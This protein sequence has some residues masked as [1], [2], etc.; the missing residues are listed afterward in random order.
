MRYPTITLMVLLGCSLAFAGRVEETDPSIA[1]GGNNVWQA[2][3]DSQASAGAYVVSGSVGATVTFNFTGTSVTLW[4]ELDPSGGSATVQIDNQP[5]GSINFYF[6]QRAYQVPAVIDQLSAGNHIIQL[7]IACTS[8]FYNSGQSG[9]PGTNIYIDAFEAPSSVTPSSDQQTAL[10]RINTFRTAAGLPAAVLSAALDLAA[11]AHADYN[12]TNQNGPGTPG[13]GLNAHVEI[14]AKPGFVGVESSDRAYYFGYPQGASE[15]AASYTD[16]TFAVDIWL[17]SVYHRSPLMSFYNTDVGFGVNKS[18]GTVLDFGSQH[19]GTLTSRQ[20][21][22]FPPNNQKNVTLQFGGETP[23]PIPNQTGPFGYPASVHIQQPANANQ[24][25]PTNP[26][27]GTLTDGAG[28]NI[29]VVLI[30]RNTNPNPG[31]LGSDDYFLVPMNPL[32]PG[33]TYTASISGTDSTGSAFSANWKFSTVPSTSIGSIFTGLQGWNYVIQWSTAGPVTSSQVNYGLTTNYGSTIAGGQIAAPPNSF[34]SS[35][36]SL[37]GGTY[38]YQITATD[39]NGTSTTPD[40][41]FVIPDTSAATIQVL[42][43]FPFASTYCYISWQTYGPVASTS[44]LYGTTTSYGQT[45]AGKPDSAGPNQWSVQFGNLTPG[46]TYHF[47]I[48]ATDS[49][50]NV[51]TTPDMTFTT[52]GTAPPSNPAPATLSGNY[53]LI[54]QNATSLCLD[55]FGAGTSPGTNV[56]AWSCNGGSNQSFN[57]VSQGNGIY[58][59][60]PNNAPGLCLD[61]YGGGTS[62]P[63]TSVDVWTC[64]GG[65]NQQWMLINDGGNVYELAPQN[66]SGLRLDVSG[67]GTSNGTQIDVWTANGGSNQKCT[68]T[69]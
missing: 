60:Q 7:T 15:D 20:I 36:A 2:V 54:P 64:T 59:I 5:W 33:T 39:A 12:G 11:Q 37:P 35:L 6:F 41:T 51:K 55:V 3:S 21:V 23:N 27:T 17:G 45:A 24:T 19:S 9:N 67:A 28:N 1:F 22:T 63:G 18:G 40:A 46:T 47:Q 49:K 26:T 4:R 31:Y 66:A 8:P 58:L 43:T 56:D 69:Q 13:V 29:G 10:A 42:G 57:L 34:L 61:V 38:H 48:M 32:N 65:T 44:V 25:N 53:K 30:D 68:V 50:G 14:P 16:P 52:P 62:A